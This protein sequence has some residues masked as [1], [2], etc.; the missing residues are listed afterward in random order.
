MRMRMRDESKERGGHNQSQQGRHQNSLL[1]ISFIDTV[2]KQVTSPGI[3]EQTTQSTIFM[4][5]SL[6]L[7]PR[8]LPPS[9]PPSIPPSLHPSTYQSLSRQC[10][11]LRTYSSISPPVFSFLSCQSSTLHQPKKT[12]SDLVRSLHCHAGNAIRKKRDK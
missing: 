9:L 7:Q 2:C 3:C 6:F 10:C 4:F 8:L 1:D 5:L 12:S 11:P